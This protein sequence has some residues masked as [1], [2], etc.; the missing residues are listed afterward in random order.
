V[1]IFSQNHP[2]SFLVSL[3]FGEGIANL[4]S[5]AEKIQSE[6]LPK[7]EKPPTQDGHDP[8]HFVTA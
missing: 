7:L 1:E 2:L 8:L 6:L 4:R 3:F 5:F